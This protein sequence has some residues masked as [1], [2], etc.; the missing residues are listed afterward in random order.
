[1]AAQIAAGKT[2]PEIVAGR[3]TGEFDAQYSTDRVDGDKFV[4][5]V[6]R[7]LTGMR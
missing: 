2:L 5:T 4:T 3:L 6:Y 7:S 1:V